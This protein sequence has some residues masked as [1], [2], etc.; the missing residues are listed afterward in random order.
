MSGFGEFAGVSTVA[1]LATV[2]TVKALKN[3]SVLS[4]PCSTLLD[5]ANGE[6]CAALLVYLGLQRML[7]SLDRSMLHANA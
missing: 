6:P 4:L 1:L 3:M 7:S 5:Q 2:R